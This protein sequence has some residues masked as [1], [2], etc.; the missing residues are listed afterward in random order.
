[1]STLTPPPLSA[2][3]NGNVTLPEGTYAYKQTG[4]QTRD[5]R[6]IEQ[7]AALAARSANPLLAAA[8]PLLRTLVDMP[9][10]MRADQVERLKIRLL[11]EIRDLQSIGQQLDFPPDYLTAASYCLCTALDEAAQG[12]SWGHYVWA[13]NSLLIQVHGENE[14]GEKVFHLLEQFTSEPTR[15]IELIELIYCLLTLGFEGRYRHMEDGEQRHHA[16][17]Q[18][19][20]G[21]IRQQRGAVPGVLPPDEPHNIGGRKHPRWE[22]PVWLSVVFCSALLLGG[23]AWA[24]HQLGTRSQLLV[25]Q[26][27]VLAQRPAAPHT[28]ARLA[29]LL[30]DEIESGT[31]S[32]SETDHEVRV[33]FRGDGMF[34]RASTSINPNILPVLNVVGTEIAKVDGSV[35]VVG[36]SDNLPIHTQSFPSNQALSQ[37]RAERVSQHLISQGVSP[38]RLEV[39]GMGDAQ[40]AADNATA[41]GR[42]QNRRVEIIVSQK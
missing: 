2:R 8:Q 33:T 18:Q 30:R 39:D 31:L 34:S 9:Q 28:G 38:H 29:E 4:P 25:Q 42:A 1:M 40:P 16:I 26:I 41:H 20:Y 7:R 22:I 24:Q 14:G 3:E 13:A 37:A 19:L 15:H 35:R 10:L 23:F 6:S 12:A 36:H 17:G 32:L 5:T 27:Q 21:L 11:Q